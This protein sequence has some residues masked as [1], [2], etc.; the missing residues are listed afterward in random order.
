MRKHL[1]II[2]QDSYS[3]LNPSM[4]IGNAIMEVMQVHCLHGNDKLRKEKV[5]EL[6]TK[7]HLN[8]DCFYRY[9]H[10]FSGGERQRICIARALAVE[11]EFIVCDE[12][13]S[14][15]DVTTQ[16]QILDLLNQL[17]TD[18]N[19][20]YLFISH[21][22]SVVNYMSSRMMVMQNGKIIEMGNA[23]EI[24]FNPQTDYARKL[25]ASIPK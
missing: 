19:L 9:P 14:S 23:E 11:P 7:T 1:Q 6:L 15:L 18:S 8:H 13:I 25:I 16:K 3:S 5:M 24:Y 21:D 20:T 12:C 10:Q 22:L 17:K 2:F 4:T